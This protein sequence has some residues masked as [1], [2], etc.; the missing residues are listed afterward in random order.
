[1][2]PRGIDDVSAAGGEETGVE[3]TAP[4]EAAKLDSGV[5]AVGR[6]EAD[7][8]AEVNSDEIG[9]GM[10]T[11]N[12]LEAAAGVVAAADSGVDTVGVGVGVGDGSRIVEITLLRIGTSPSTVEVDEAAADVEAGAD[13]PPVPENVTPEVIVALSEVEIGVTIGVSFGEDSGV[14]LDDD[15]DDPR[16]PP[17]PKVIPLATGEEAVGIS[18]GVAT[19]LEAT[20]GKTTT[21]GTGLDEAA[22]EDTPNRL[23]S[24]SGLDVEAATGVESAPTVVVCWMIT[25]ITPSL[26]VA[27]F[28]LS[29]LAKRSPPVVPALEDARSDSNSD[30]EERF[31]EEEDVMTSCDDSGVGVSFAAGV[32]MV[33]LFSKRGL[34]IARGK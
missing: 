14:L 20:V 16:T 1:M 5:T 4:V 32:V 24:K 12:E 2:L 23:A 21:G 11:G 31:V 22:A 33:E 15:P 7:P 8:G 6:S 29:K 18:A 3:T 34:L 10:I 13:V 30:S 27:G 19:A 17:G 9:T 28:E 25:V 26:D